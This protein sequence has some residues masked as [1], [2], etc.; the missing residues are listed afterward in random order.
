[1]AKSPR[2]NFVLPFELRKRVDAVSKQTGMPLSLVIRKA[3][4][5]Y[6]A[7]CEEKFKQDGASFN[8]EPDRHGR[9]WK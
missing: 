5:G 8:M 6:L 7:F 4:E 1:M 3:L 9:Y 2:I